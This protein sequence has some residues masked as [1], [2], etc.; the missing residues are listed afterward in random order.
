MVGRIQTQPKTNPPLFYVI[1][2]QFSEIKAGNISDP[3]FFL[4]LLIM[5]VPFDFTLLTLGFCSVLNST[6]LL[7]CSYWGR[8]GQSVRRP[9]SDAS[10]ANWFILVSTFFNLIQ[11]DWIFYEIKIIEMHDGEF[12]FFFINKCITET[13]DFILQKYIFCLSSQQFVQ[14]VRGRPSAAGRRLSGNRCATTQK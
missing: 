7:A 1:W 8:C 11:T 2:I 14:S 3:H 5:F 12:S 4:S 6:S 13:F 10:P 9:P